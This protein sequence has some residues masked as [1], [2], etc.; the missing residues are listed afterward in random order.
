MIGKII[1][2]SLLLL[3][4]NISCANADSIKCA[5]GVVASISVGA[6]GKN[7]GV[8]YDEGNSIKVFINDNNNNNKYYVNTGHNLKN[9]PGYA[10]LDLLLYA[11][12]TG[13]K[14]QLYNH[15]QVP[16]NNKFDEVVLL[17]ND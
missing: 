3:I 13:T 6:D 7:Q 17:K 9:S 12:A 2:Y 16:C 15:S 4:S 1:F 14:V 8:A 10:L 11:K 5:E